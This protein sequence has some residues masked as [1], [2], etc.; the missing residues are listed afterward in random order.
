MSTE[1]I[2][3]GSEQYVEEVASK[4]IAGQSHRGLSLAPPRPEQQLFC[5]YSDL[6]QVL[7]QLSMATTAWD[8]ATDNVGRGAFW[9]ASDPDREVRV[10]SKHRLTI[11]ADMLTKSFEFPETIILQSSCDLVFVTIAQ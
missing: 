6:H 11:L 3:G 2:M 9:R 10:G 4:R 5:T 1:G 8:P 7:P